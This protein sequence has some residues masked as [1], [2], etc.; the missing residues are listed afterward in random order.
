MELAVKKDYDVI[1]L[2]HRMPGMDGIQT[3]AAMWM[4]LVRI[5]RLC[6]HY[7]GVIWKSSP[8]WWQKMTPR[9]KNALLRKNWQKRGNP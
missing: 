7:A 4:K 3:L 6:W 8:R 2:D 5:R 9:R 1:F